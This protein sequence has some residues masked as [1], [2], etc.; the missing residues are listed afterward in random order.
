MN[1]HSDDPRAKLRRSVYWLL[2]ISSIGAMTGRV[3]TVQSENGKT[4]FLGANDRSRWCTIRALVDHGTYEIDKVVIKGDPQSASPAFD[5]NWQT[6][7]MVRHR[8][9][10]KKEH[11]YSSKPPLLPTL[12]ACEYW[13]LKSTIGATLEKHPFYVGRWILIVSNIVPLLIGFILLG[14]IVERYG[15]TDWGRIFVMACATW[16]TFLTTYAVTLNNHLPAA[17]SVLIAVYAGLLVWRERKLCWSYFVIAGLFSAFAAANE[18]PAVSFLVLIA[19]A[20]AI[21][22]P[23]KTLVAFVPSAAII[24]AAFFYTNHLAHGTWRPAYMH[25]QDGKLIASVNLDQESSLEQGEIP[26]ALRDKLANVIDPKPILLSDSAKVSP[27]TEAPRVAGLMSWLQTPPPP[28]EKRW[29]V[30]DPDGHDRVAIVRREG[31]KTLDVHAWGNWYEY[32][33]SYWTSGVKKGVDVGERSRGVYAFNMLIG[34]YGVFSLTPIWLLSLV[35]IG[36]MLFSSERNMR[37]FAILVLFLTALCVAF[38]ILRP[39]EDRNYGGVASGFRWLFWFIPLWLI[40]LLPVA[41]RM[42]GSR[43]WRGLALIMLAVSV[44]SA[45]YASLNPWTHSWIYN[46][47]EYI[48]VWHYFPWIRG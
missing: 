26:D 46:Y 47:S 8:G 10:D 41:D 15:T 38:Y 17:I 24:V 7:D 19:I 4:P 29:V 9:R 2:I 30:F 6:I 12:L 22:S 43:V 45:G 21:R 11:Y 42:S 33:G 16:G 34:H 18:L 5:E 28:V 3:L 25:R 20:L 27:A 40:C 32:D 37:G 13:L 31:A 36:M 1:D 39:L 23:L 35:G 44:I 48:Q 14:R